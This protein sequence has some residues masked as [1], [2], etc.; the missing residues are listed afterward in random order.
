[1]RRVLILL[2][3]VSLNKATQLTETIVI[4]GKIEGSAD[5]TSD[6]LTGE[7]I[8]GDH[9]LHGE[10]VEIYTAQ[11]IELL[12]PVQIMEPAVFSIFL[13]TASIDS[14]RRQEVDLKTVTLSNIE[15]TLSMQN[16]GKA[17]PTVGLLLP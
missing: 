14:G 15:L 5:L 7:V 12:S 8:G 17:S 3:S 11:G 2:L 9:Q 4:D 6:I 10:N 1:M 13:T 16:I